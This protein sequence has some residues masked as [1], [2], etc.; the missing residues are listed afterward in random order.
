MRAYRLVL[1]QESIPAAIGRRAVVPLAWAG[2][3]VLA[4]LLT[5]PAGHLYT[6][7]GSTH[8]ADNCFPAQVSSA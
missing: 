6:S 8:G 4:R 1:R 7:S 3:E 2:S 5:T